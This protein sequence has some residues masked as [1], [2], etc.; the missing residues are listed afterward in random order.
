MKLIFSLILNISGNPRW[1]DDKKYNLETPW[2]LSR[3]IMRNSVL[4]FKVLELIYL[5][6]IFF[7]LELLFSLGV[8]GRY[9]KTNI[10]D[11][12]FLSSCLS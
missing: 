8:N 10:D 3:L 4:L 5:E 12:F 2:T 7:S 9:L 1:L 11:F 6:K